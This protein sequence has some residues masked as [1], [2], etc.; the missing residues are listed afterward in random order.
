M[1]Y[2]Q[3]LAGTVTDLKDIGCKIE[4]VQEELPI[5]L[6]R[7]SIRIEGLKEINYLYTFQ[8]GDPLFNY[9]YLFIIKRLNLC[10]DN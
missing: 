10:L 6:N 7:D 8:K 4:I 3:K 2:L 1:W 9:I 5:I